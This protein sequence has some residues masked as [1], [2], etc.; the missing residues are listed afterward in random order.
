[1]LI[2]TVIKPRTLRLG[3]EPLEC[4]WRGE[5]N[6]N[7]CLAGRSEGKK[8]SIFW[9]ITPCT[10]LKVNGRFGGTYRLHLQCPRISQAKKPASA[11]VVSRMTFNGLHGVITQ[12][13]E[14]FVTTGVKTSNPTY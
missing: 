8:S 7:N 12:K 6:E 2:I 4:A 14:L 11:Q 1:L 13:I 5:Q 3:E 9:Y 10:P